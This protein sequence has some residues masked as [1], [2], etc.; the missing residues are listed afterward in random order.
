M[1]T[2]GSAMDIKD[3]YLKVEQSEVVNATIR[4]LIALADICRE[5]GRGQLLESCI[6]LDR[7]LRSRLWEGTYGSVLLNL[8]STFSS[9]YLSTHFPASASLSPNTRQRLMH[10][11]LRTVGDLEVPSYTPLIPS[12]TP[13]MPSHILSHP[14][15][16]L[17]PLSY[18]STLTYSLILSPPPPIP[19]HILSHPLTPLHTLPYPSHTPHILSHPYILSRTLPSLSPPP[20]ILSHPYILSRTLFCTLSY[21]L[22]LSLILSHTLSY[23]YTP[24]SYLSRM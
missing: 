17:H 7:A 12:H 9:S 8:T 13:R 14:L 4:T 2:T 15:T 11:G 24:L 1:S 18:P 23:P 5:R 6:L 19:S 21:S 16:P 10:A 3:F 22:T 20:H